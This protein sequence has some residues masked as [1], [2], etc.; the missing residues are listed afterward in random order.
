MDKHQ[1]QQLSLAKCSRQ[2][3]SE[4]FVLDKSLFSHV[5]IHFNL[6]SFLFLCALSMVSFSCCSDHCFYQ[7]NECWACICSVIL[8]QSILVRMTLYYY[9]FEQWRFVLY[10]L[11]HLLAGWCL[12][13]AYKIRIQFGTS[14]VIFQNSFC[15]SFCNQ[16]GCYLFFGRI[17]RDVP[18]DITI[19]VS[20][21]TF[22][23]HK[24]SSCRFILVLLPIHLEEK[25]NRKCMHVFSLYI[26]E[27]SI[28][29][30]TDSWWSFLKNAVPSSFSKWTNQKVGC[31]T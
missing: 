23:L 31:R 16:I 9:L 13:S 5:R 24:V 12:H 4:W 8:S 2:K 19:E 27:I 14:L 10:V 15:C 21:G 20:G 30:L 26:Y 29:V 11:C 7:H 17:F 3:Y 6:F 28:M 22:A 25:L 18:S 1:Q